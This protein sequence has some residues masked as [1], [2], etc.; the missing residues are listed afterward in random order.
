MDDHARQAAENI[1]ALGYEIGSSSKRQAAYDAA[2]AEQ[3]GF[4]GFY[5]LILEAGAAL[6]KLE[7]EKKVNW[8]VDADFILMIEAA[9]E[10]LLDFMIERGYYPVDHGTL[11]EILNSCLEKSRYAAQKKDPEVP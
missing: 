6:T 2:L 1:A 4:V 7:I 9:S 11:M 8:G 10:A 5:D 3:D